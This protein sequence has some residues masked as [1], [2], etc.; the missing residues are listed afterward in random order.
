MATKA[1]QDF[2]LAM[3]DGE[4]AVSIL[5]MVE[6]AVK[7]LDDD[8]ANA[9]IVEVAAKCGYHFSSLD[10]YEWM[11]R[12]VEQMKRSGN[13]AYLRELRS[14]WGNY[15]AALRW[16]FFYQKFVSPRF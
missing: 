13:D 14:G 2:V 6:Y 5:P 16:A 12:Y 10:A 11:E 3:R 7:G 1:V 15:W 8:E 9:A 4:S